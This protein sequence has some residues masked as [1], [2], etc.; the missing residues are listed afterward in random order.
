METMMLPQGGHGFSVVDDPVDQTVAGVEYKRSSRIEGAVF[1]ETS[2]ARAI[3]TEFPAADARAATAALNEMA[4]PGYLRAPAG[5]TVSDQELALR[6]S[7]TP[8]L[9]SEFADRA[10]ARVERHDFAG[11]LADYDAALKLRPDDAAL[12]NSRCFTRGIANTALDEAMAD[13]NAALADQPRDPA[14]L[15]SRGFIYFRLG[16]LERAIDDLDAA[17]AVAPNQA[18]SLYVRGVIERRIGNA[19]QS[20]ADIAAAE[21]LDAAIAATYAGYG[22]R[23]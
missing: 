19:R 14:F 11:A 20:A 2:S 5:Y 18:N 17:L 10:E 13:C 23:P 1:T 7:R 12:L 9:A 6:L 8:T 21:A 16:N 4:L 3:A 22:V 15:D